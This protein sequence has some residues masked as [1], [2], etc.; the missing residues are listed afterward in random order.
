MKDWV[1]G[2]QTNRRVQDNTSSNS[3]ETKYK[4]IWM[5]TFLIQMINKIKQTLKKAFNAKQKTYQK[6]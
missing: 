4:K 1:E 2:T 6:T 3:S 5:Q